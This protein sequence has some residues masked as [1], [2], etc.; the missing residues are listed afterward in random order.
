MNDLVRGKGPS[1]A[2][3]VVCQFS[4]FNDIVEKAGLNRPSGISKERIFVSDKL[5]E[6][7]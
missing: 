3:A 6:T 7:L 1:E 4:D 2:C 5:W